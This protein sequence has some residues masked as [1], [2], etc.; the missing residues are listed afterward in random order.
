MRKLIDIINDEKSDKEPISTGFEL[1]D[2]C[3]IQGFRKS[4]LIIIGARPAMGKTTFAVNLA[5][6]IARSGKKCVFFSLE[7]SD[8]ML[9][10]KFSTVNSDMEIY[11]DDK[12][13]ITVS[14]MNQKIKDL[15][16]VDCVIIDYF[17]LI[18]SEI[19]RTSRIWENHDISRELKRMAKGLDVSVICTAQVAKSETHDECHQIFDLLDEDSLEL[20]A[21]IFIFLHRDNFTFKNM[22]NRNPD[23][24]ELIIAKNRYGDIG[25]INLKYNSEEK[26]FTETDD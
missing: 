16:S 18:R 14:E 24:T 1:L 23:I 21:D 26:N 8:E 3:Y 17:S 19:K 12:P 10:K 5:E 9:A 13:V 15:K 2:A 6:N 22:D 11:I 7:M 4:D 25:V 20:Y